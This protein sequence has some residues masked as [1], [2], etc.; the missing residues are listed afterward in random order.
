MLG[1]GVGLFILAAAQGPIE[2]MGV[3]PLQHLQT[4]VTSLRPNQHLV[5]STN[6]SVRAQSGSQPRK[7][8]T[9]AKGAKS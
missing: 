6:G 7:M 5:I 8:S 3:L 1:F 4:P 2:H 9:L